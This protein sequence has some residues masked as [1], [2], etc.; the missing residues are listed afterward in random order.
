[1]GKFPVAGLPG[2]QRLLLVGVGRTSRAP[3]SPMDANVTTPLPALLPE[4]QA[5][6]R[7]WFA[8]EVQPHEGALRAYLRGRFPALPDHDDVVQE[9]FV[10]VIR[11]HATGKLQVP[12][13]FLFVTARNVALDHFRR[14]KTNP[15]MGLVNPDALTVVEE[16]SLVGPLNHEQDLEV[17]EEAIAALPERCRQIIMLKK[18][19]G[20]SYD[21]IGARLGIAP[22]TISQQLSIGVAKCRA[23]F[24]R[25]GLLK[26]R[27]T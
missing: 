14:E 13:A 2:I 10:R 25:R 12:R 27:E 6:V 3:E 19:Q 20:L 15:V 4:P 26:G 21:E 1:M 7:S 16:G 5:E 23:F 9:A 11:A 8:A 24:A 17:L 22:G 18:I